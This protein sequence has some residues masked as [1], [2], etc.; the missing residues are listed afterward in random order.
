MTNDANCTNHKLMIMV[1]YAVL[2]PMALPWHDWYAA[3]ADPDGING[4]QLCC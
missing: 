1:R 4:T 2:M 3:I